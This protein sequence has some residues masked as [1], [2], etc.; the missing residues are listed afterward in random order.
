MKR[1]YY[2]QRI[3]IRSIAGQEMKDEV[4]NEKAGS[5]SAGDFGDIGVINKIGM[6]K[7]KNRRKWEYLL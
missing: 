7:H 5:E 1:V 2:K 3:N 4:R 6:G